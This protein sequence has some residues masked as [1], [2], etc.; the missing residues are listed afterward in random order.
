MIL[1][2]DIGH[3]FKRKITDGL[4]IKLTNPWPASYLCLPVLSILTK[5]ENANQKDHQ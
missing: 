2:T 3:I 5:T 4:Q 1:A